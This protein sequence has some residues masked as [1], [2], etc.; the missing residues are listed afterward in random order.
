MSVAGGNGH[1]LHNRERKP[2]QC[3]AEIGYHKITE[4]RLRDVGLRPE[5]VARLLFVDL[6]WGTRAPR[7]L[8]IPAASG[9][10]VGRR[11]GLEGAELSE[12]AGSSVHVMC[13]NSSPTPPPP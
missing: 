12:A 13:Q 8:L 6:G 2:S 7:K 4:M 1:E 10:W 3:L 11:S 5:S 9:S